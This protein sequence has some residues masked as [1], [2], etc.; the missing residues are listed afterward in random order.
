MKKSVTKL[1]T[2]AVLTDNKYDQEDE[3]IVIGHAILAY[4]AIHNDINNCVLFISTTKFTKGTKRGM[5]LNFYL[6]SCFFVLFVVIY[7]V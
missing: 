3:S 2:F 4:G 1:K 5:V 7:L 6:T